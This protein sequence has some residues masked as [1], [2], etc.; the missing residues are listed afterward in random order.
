M[1]GNLLKYGRA[2]AKI[3][4]YSCFASHGMGVVSSLI[5]LPVGHGASCMRVTRRLLCVSVRSDDHSYC[6]W[7]LQLLSLP[8]LNA[9][10]SRCS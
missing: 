7:S 5:L 8:Q 2:I 4:R 10:L 3:K 9:A 1:I 6:C